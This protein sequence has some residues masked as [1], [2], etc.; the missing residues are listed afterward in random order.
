MERN[1]NLP[2]GKTVAGVDGEGQDF[3]DVFYLP[4]I[5]DT[6]GFGKA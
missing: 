5:S 1:F 2:G 6:H 3:F 4:W